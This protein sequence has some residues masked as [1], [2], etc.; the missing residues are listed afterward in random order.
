MISL[1]WQAY[2][3]RNYSKSANIISFLRKKTLPKQFT[4]L[5]PP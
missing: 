4:F 5:L 3:D 1:V 2:I